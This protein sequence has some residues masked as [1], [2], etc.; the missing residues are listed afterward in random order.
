MKDCLKCPQLH[1]DFC[2]CVVDSM[3]EYKKKQRD[4]NVNDTIKFLIDNNIKYKE[5][6]ISNIVIVNPDVDDL[7]L[8]LKK[9]GN[10]FKCR[11][12]GSNVWYLYS[13]NKFIQKFKK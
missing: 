11:F 7:S 10:L 2:T 4:E 6:K 12:K 9:A 13:N 5:S 3:R 1:K 8:S